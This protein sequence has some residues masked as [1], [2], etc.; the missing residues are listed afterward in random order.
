LGPALQRLR[1]DF[2]KDNDLEDDDDDGMILWKH[3]VGKQVKLIEAKYSKHEGD[4]QQFLEDVAYI[5]GGIADLQLSGSNEIRD[6]SLLSG[7][8]DHSEDPV[9]RLN[10]QGCMTGLLWGSIAVSPNL[11]DVTLLLEGCSLDTFTVVPRRAYRKLKF[12][13]CKTKK[14]NADRMLSSFVQAD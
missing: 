3:L 1:L 13:E 9:E 8:L 14:F 12:F 7:F 4:H 5:S 2:T 6:A 10:W 11:L